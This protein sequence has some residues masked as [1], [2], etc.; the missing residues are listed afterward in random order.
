MAQADQG[1]PSK[2]YGEFVKNIDFT[3]HVWHRLTKMFRLGGLRPDLQNQGAIGLA[4]ALTHNSVY[5]H[6]DEV[7]QLNAFSSSCDV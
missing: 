6:S 5:D 2:L 7:G 3:P 4:V 1:G